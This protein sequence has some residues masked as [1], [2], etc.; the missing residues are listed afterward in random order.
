MSL[1]DFSEFDNEEFTRSNLAYM[2]EFIDKASNNP[3]DDMFGMLAATIVQFVHL[4]RKNCKK[5]VIDTNLLSNE[6][7]VNVQ[8]DAMRQ[9]II[10]LEKAKSGFNPTMQ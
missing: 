3:N 9:C 2:Q 5:R 10:D 7:V 1:E 8:I 6:D 4:V